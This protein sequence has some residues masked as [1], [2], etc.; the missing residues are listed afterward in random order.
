MLRLA[1]RCVNGSLLPAHV[2]PI[3]LALSAPSRAALRRPDTDARHVTP[4]RAHPANAV[5]PAVGH[6]GPT[7]FP[8]SA[9]AYSGFVQQRLTRPPERG[10]GL[11]MSW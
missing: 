6:P 7:L 9:F 2:S 3:L 5:M 8:H 4:S 1:L 11:I 10:A